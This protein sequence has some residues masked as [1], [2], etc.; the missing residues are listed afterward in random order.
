MRSSG[1]GRVRCLLLA[2]GIN[3][4][5]GEDTLERISI[6]SIDV[7]TDFDISGS[8]ARQRVDRLA[9]PRRSSAPEVRG[10]MRVGYR[11]TRS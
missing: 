7:H 10:I 9:E 5:F 2:L 11:F 4:G 6:D 8:R 3:A 1:L